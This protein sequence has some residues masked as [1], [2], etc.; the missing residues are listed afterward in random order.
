[1]VRLKPINPIEVRETLHDFD[2][3]IEY[4]NGGEQMAKDIHAGD[5][6]AI[7]CQTSTNEEYWILICD[8]G[9]HMVT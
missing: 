4:G 7:K 5:N 3:K 8:K 1:L 6:V 9:L 2:T